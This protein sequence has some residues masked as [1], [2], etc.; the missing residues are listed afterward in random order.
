MDKYSWTIV[1]I[2]WSIRQLFPSIAANTVSSKSILMRQIFFFACV[3]HKHQ[4]Q[5]RCR[6]VPLYGH[7]IVIL[8]NSMT[9]PWLTCILIIWAFYYWIIV[10]QFAG[11]Y[12]LHIVSGN[13][14]QVISTTRYLSDPYWSDQSPCLVSKH[15]ILPIQFNSVPRLMMCISPHQDWFHSSQ[16]LHRTL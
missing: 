5:S 16:K 12:L 8:L 6:K 2:P 7:C 15:W 13:C 4:H 10:C 11:P 1:C 3:T 9:V 14:S